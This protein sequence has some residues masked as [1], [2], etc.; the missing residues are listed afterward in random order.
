MAWV[1]QKSF[2]VLV[3]LLV[4][5]PVWGESEEPSLEL[6]EFLA[7]WQNEEGDWV[8]PIEFVGGDERVDESEKDEENSYE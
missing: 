2:W 8:D 4:A 1:N 6:L 5:V 7:D 3:L